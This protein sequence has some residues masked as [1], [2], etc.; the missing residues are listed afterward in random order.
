M[1]EAALKRAV[2]ERHPRVS[3]QIAGKLPG[4]MVRRRED[5]ERYFRQQCERNCP[6]CIPITQWLEKIAEALE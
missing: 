5:R 2:V 6:Q 4:W 1:S 3:F